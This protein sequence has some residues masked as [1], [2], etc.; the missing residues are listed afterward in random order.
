MPK[1]HSSS[2]LDKTL[3]SIVARAAGEIAH[4]VRQNIAH[5]VTSLVG[6]GRKAL[7]QGGLAKLGRKRKVITCPSC[8]KP[9][10]GP[11]WG[12]FCKDHKD[13]SES[14]KNQ[15]RAKVRSRP[16][17][18]ARTIRGGAKKRRGPGRPKGSKNQIAAKR[19]PGRPKGS[20]NKR[21]GRLAKARSAKKQNSRATTAPTIQPAVA[22]GATA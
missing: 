11:K 15:A 8:G 14:E 1:T 22:A 6:L 21:K 7:G 5:E 20:K 19:G 13:L 17:A 4:A 3:S 9:G 10:G 18:A 16:V 2:D 12:W